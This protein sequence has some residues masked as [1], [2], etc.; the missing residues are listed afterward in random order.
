M[1]EKEIETYKK[2]KEELISK[3]LGKFVLI[4]E[5][6]IIGIFESQK[7]AINEGI[8]KYGNN[9]FLVKKIEE[10]EQTQNFTSNLIMCDLKC[11]H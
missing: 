8:K 9:E 2:N 1:L 5:N 3:H 10:V 4:K 6:K 11:L 7:D